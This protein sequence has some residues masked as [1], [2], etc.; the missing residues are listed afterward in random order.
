MTLLKDSIGGPYNEWSTQGTVT[1][2]DLA[3]GVVYKFTVYSTNGVG[4]GASSSE[5]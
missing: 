4:T 5:V 1:A 2:I 3:D